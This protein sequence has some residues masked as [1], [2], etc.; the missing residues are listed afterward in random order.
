MSF[1]PPLDVNKTRLVQQHIGD[2]VHHDRLQDAQ[3][4]ASTSKDARILLLILSH[5]PPRGRYA[6]PAENDATG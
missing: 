6:S 2:D 1:H 4:A 5:E 3:P